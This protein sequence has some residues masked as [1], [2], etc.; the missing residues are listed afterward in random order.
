[1]HM[2]DSLGLSQTHQKMFKRSDV[3]EIFPEYY[4]LKVNNL[5]DIARDTLDKW[6][7]FLKNSEIKKE[8]KAKGLQKAA[9][10]LNIMRLSEEKRKEYEHFICN[11]RAEESLVWNSHIEGKIEGS[12]KPNVRLLVS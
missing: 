7:Y 11:R 10:K 5:D 9:E 4:I 2:H 8:F 1:M 3:A 6:M 12:C